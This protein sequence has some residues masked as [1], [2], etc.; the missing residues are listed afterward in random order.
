[1]NFELNEILTII[2]KVKTTGL[3]TFEYQDTDVKLKIRGQKTEMT[4]GSVS[5]GSDVA[6]N[7]VS[8]NEMAFGG[9]IIG[10]AGELVGAGNV[11]GNDQYVESPMV[12]TFYHAPAEDADPFVSV[13]DRV[14]KGQIIGIIEAM[15]L[16]NEIP[17]EVDGIVEEILVDN[18]T[19]VEFGQPLI[20][21][22]KA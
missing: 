12:G 10:N 3:D 4:G 18:E 21:M 7:G 13:G 16:M 19:V 6:G 1:M 8:R 17:S 11:N 9:G 20:R 2:D 15:K 22:R 5:N 14:T